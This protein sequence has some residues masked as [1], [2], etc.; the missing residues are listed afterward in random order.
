MDAASRWLTT[1]NDVVWK[2]LVIEVTRSIR[3]PTSSIQSRTAASRAARL[4]PSPFSVER[5]A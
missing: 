4:D 3:T 5:L 1:K 2:L